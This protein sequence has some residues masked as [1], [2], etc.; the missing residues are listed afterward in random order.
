MLAWL[1]KSGGIPVVPTCLE[2]WQPRPGYTVVHRDLA[3]GHLVVPV[4]DATPGAIP[5]N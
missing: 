1:T 2:G 4:A 3:D 5:S